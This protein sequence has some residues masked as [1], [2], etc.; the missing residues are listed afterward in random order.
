LNV[1]QAQPALAILHHLT[2]T[3]RQTGN[4]ILGQ[5]RN[6][7]AHLVLSMSG[8]KDAVRRPV[9]TVEPEKSDTQKV[10]WYF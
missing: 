10:S 6:K 3:L 7:S 5:K 1:V 4:L 8:D 9:G 2:G